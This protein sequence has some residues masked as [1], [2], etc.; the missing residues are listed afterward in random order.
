MKIIIFILLLTSFSFAQIQLALAKGAAAK[1][2]LAPASFTNLELTRLGNSTVFALN[3]NAYLAERE[4]DA[5]EA[6][7]HIPAAQRQKAAMLA[8]GNLVS[9]NQQLFVT[10]N[11]LEEEISRRLGIKTE[12][13]REFYG[14]GMV[15]NPEVIIHKTYDLQQLIA[16]LGK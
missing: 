1:L 7:R 4:L 12:R 5:V 15:S 10:A 13:S 6:Q 11:Q 8:T 14:V 9:D 2:A 16:R 3:F